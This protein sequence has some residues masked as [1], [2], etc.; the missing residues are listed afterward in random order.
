MPNSMSKGG[1][2]LNE[3]RYRSG[4]I[5]FAGASALTASVPTLVTDG[6]DI[7]GASA[8]TVDLIATTTGQTLTGLGTI[9]FWR[10]NPDASL[11]LP[12]EANGVGQG[13]QD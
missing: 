4:S 9:E 8:F 10:W 1:P 5:V 3:Q 6:F 11:W 2:L 13:N 12:P 7:E